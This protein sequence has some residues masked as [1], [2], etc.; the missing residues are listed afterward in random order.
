M[1]RVWLLGNRKMRPTNQLRYSCFFLGAPDKGRPTLNEELTA[2]TL[3]LSLHAKIVYPTT[4]HEGPEREYRYSRTPSLTSGLDRVGG[5]R[6]AS[7]PSV[8]A[9]II[10]EAEWASGPVWTGKENFVCTG[11]WSPARP[12]PSEPLYPLRYP[13]TLSTHIPYHFVI[14][15]KMVITWYHHHQHHVVLQ[16]VRRVFQSASLFNFRYPLVPIM[17][18]S[19]C[20]HLLPRIPAPFMLPSITCFRRHFLCKIWPIHWASLR[21]ILCRMFLSSLTL[22]NMPSLLTRSAQLIISILLQHHISKLHYM[23]K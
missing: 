7:A 16:H 5:L 6:H 15:A 13:S 11:I 9:P 21:F 22:C 4:G 2:T 1:R 10:Q 18:S 8:P 17:S 19:S 3:F 14:A 12:A 23:T 20:L